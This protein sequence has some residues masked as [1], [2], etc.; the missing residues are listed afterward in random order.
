MSVDRLSR[1]DAL[2]RHSKSHEPFEI[3]LQEKYLP[4]FK[5]LEPRRKNHP[6]DLRLLIV[7]GLSLQAQARER[8]VVIKED[9]DLRKLYPEMADMMGMKLP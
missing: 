1:K 6:E 3:L 9:E 8:G 7:V 2:K 4:V 5:L